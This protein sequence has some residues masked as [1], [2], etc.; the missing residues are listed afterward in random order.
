MGRR[1]PLGSWSRRTFVTRAATAVGA[2]LVTQATWPD[3]MVAQTPPC[4]TLPA[5]ELL[6][7]VPLYGPGAADVPLGTIVGGHGLDARQYTDLSHLTPSALVTPSADV[8]VRTAAPAALH[9]EPAS[10]T[11]P[12]RDLTGATLGTLG[13]TEIARASA[14]RGVH[15]IECAGNSN[16]QN[17][18]L[19]S[20][21]AWDG[22]P[23]STVLARWP[24]P[25]GAT[26]LLVSG[27]DHDVP[28]S[29]RSLPGASWVLPL[30]RLTADGAFLAVRMNGEALSAHHGAPVRLVVP[31]WYGCA[32]IKWVN[33]LRWVGA[34][35]ESTTQMLEFAFRT[36]QGG[37]PERAAEYEAPEVDIAAMPI[38]VEQRRVAGRTVYDVVGLVWGGRRPV[39]QLLIKFA[40][41][42]RG[43]PVR[44]CPPPATT[45]TWTLWTYRW[46]PDAPGY[47]DITLKAADPTVRTRRLDVSFYLRRVKIEEV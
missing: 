36:H 38:R 12:V 30:D 44:V 11:I 5:G 42:D 26:A 16:P 46:T 8:F 2:S 35:A 15:L 14:P 1:S 21:A 3:A 32:W 20:A 29:T 22:V 9:P 43:V 23:L 4:P 31:G 13:A 7:L 37:I 34:D 25:S 19:M 33:A 17:F 10:W 47:Y 28:E 39:D 27:L 6:G 41:R 45:A 40:S 24:R 18:G